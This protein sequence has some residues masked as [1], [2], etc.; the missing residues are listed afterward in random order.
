MKIDKDELRKKITKQDMDK[1][2]KVLGKEN[3]AIIKKFKEYM[4]D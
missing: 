2:E 3:E 1:L 4:K